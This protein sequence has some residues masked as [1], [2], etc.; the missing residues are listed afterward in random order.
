MKKAIADDE[1][2][3]HLR[4]FCRVTR[5]IDSNTTKTSGWV[6]QETRQAVE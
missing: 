3:N 4:D 1:K 6:L 5:S 2:Y